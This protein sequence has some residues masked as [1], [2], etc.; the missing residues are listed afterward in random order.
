LNRVGEDAYGVGPAFPNLGLPFGSVVKS[1]MA[2]TT[3]CISSL[4]YYPL[5]LTGDDVLEES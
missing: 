4:L 1:H 5:E 2:S 3:S